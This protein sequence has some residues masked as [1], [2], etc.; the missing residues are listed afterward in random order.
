MC[1][2]VKSLE[3]PQES[4]YPVELT[5]IR[6]EV[7]LW[8]DGR[9]LPVWYQVILC[10]CL[11]QKGAPPLGSTLPHPCWKVPHQWFLWCSHPYIWSLSWGCYNQLSYWDICVPSHVWPLVAWSS[12]TAHWDQLWPRPGP[13]HWCGK[14]SCHLCAIGLYIGIHW[15]ACLFTTHS[16]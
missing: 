2:N 16:S 11:H 14:F 15:S 9:A 5:C 8:D 1:N 10:L 7:W 3:M 6:T 12:H 13:Y 4:V